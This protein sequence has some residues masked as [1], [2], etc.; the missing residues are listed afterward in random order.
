MKKLNNKG[1]TLIELLAVVVILLAISIIAISSISSAIERT[2]NKQDD[3]K[4]QAIIEAA[5]LYFDEHKNNTSCECVYVENLEDLNKADLEKSDGT[6]FNGYVTKSG[7]E[8]VEGNRRCT[9][10]C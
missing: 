9:K 4:K 1:F 5:K 2:K 6:F 10:S 3:A 8:Y 7:Y